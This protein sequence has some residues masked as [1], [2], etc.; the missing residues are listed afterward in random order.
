MPIELFIEYNC[1][2]KK[3]INYLKEK[4]SNINKIIEVC[5]VAEHNNKIIAITHVKLERM[6][7]SHI[8]KFGIAIIKGYR[9]LGLGEYLLTEIVK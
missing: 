2:D 5:L 4:I 7:R 3:S 6:R 1:F 8:G 9:G